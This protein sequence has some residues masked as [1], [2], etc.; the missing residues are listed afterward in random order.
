[1]KSI[2]EVFI[3]STI[4]GGTSMTCEAYAEAKKMHSLNLMK[5]TNP[6]HQ[7]RSHNLKQVPQIKVKTKKIYV[8][9][10]KQ[11]IFGYS[12]SF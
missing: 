4:R 1:M 3:E 9:F 10:I 2:N 11:K 12:L 5:L 6:L 7:G 8:Y